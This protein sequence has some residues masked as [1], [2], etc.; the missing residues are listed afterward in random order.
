MA[1]NQDRAEPDLRPLDVVLIGGGLA[2]C[3]VALALAKFHPEL[4]V[5]LVEQSGGLGGNHTWCFHSADFEA[6]GW[7]LLQAAVTQMWT[8]YDVR[9]PD[10]ERTVPSAY[11]VITSQRLEGAVKAAW[12]PLA[13]FEFMFHQSARLVE[14]NRVVLQNGEELHAKWVLDAR[15]PEQMAL[16]DGRRLYQKFL[17]LELRLATPTSRSIPLLMDATV[18]QLDGFRFM[19]VLPFEPLRILVED[20]YFSNTAELDLVALRKRTLDYVK[21]LGLEVSDVLREE[22][23]VLPMPCQRTA[24]FSAESPLKL[25][26]AGGWFHPT[27][28]YSLPLAARVAQVFSQPLNAWRERLQELG[29][30]HAR[31][32]RFAAF[33]NR[34]LFQGFKPEQRWN[35][36]SRFYGFDEAMIA[37]FYALRMTH[38]DRFRVLCGRPPRGLSL[39]PW[40]TG[41]SP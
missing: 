32:F 22:V 24:E 3:C 35:V 10:R 11:G 34:L 29:S 31:Q 14:S 12:A 8:E 5:A 30:L 36:F 1:Q 41:V 20:T 23:G 27:T 19:Y 4:R 28:G 40:Q 26:Y 18:P 25:G 37:R 16:T 38:S 9:F 15:G 7:S 13:S 6:R 33:L 2:N 39:N 21:S 17:G